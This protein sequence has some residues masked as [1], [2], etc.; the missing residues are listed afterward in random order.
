M[1]KYQDFVGK[2]LDIPVICST[3][4]KIP[5]LAS[6][7]NTSTNTMNTTPKISISTEF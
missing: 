7:I 3:K 1:D 6:T 2:K 5:S 4:L